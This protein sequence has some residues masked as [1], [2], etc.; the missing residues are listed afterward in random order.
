L[1]SRFPSVC[2]DLTSAFD[3][4]ASARGTQLPKFPSTTDFLERIAR[5]DAGSATGIPEA[6]L[7]TA[8]MPGQR[9]HRPLPYDIDVVAAVTAEGRLQIEMINRGSAGAVISVHD[10]LDLQEP[11]HYTIGA[12]DRLVSEQWHDDGPLDAYDLTLRGP[13]GFWRRFAGSLKPDAPRAEVAIMLHP[14]TGA[15]ELIMRNGGT[16]PMVFTIALDE[17]YPTAGSRKRTVRVGA[18]TEAREHWFLLKSDHWFDFLVMLEGTP[19][20]VRRFAGKIETGKPGRTD[21]G[22]GPICMT[23]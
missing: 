23:L 20:F 16:K 15:A 22:I 7:P 6:Q 12:G 3:F 1:L 17:H 5:S 4:T 11:R 18:G 14:D 2:G 8:Q 9:P 10:N 13:N 19:E 21:P